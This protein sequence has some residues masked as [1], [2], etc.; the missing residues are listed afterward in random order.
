MA[1]AGSREG[2]QARELRLLFQKMGSV[3]VCSVGAGGVVCKSKA[4]WLG[5]LGEEC[6]WQ[7]WKEKG[8]A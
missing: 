6:R 8:A 2:S 1:I 3:R 5:M 4:A 7:A